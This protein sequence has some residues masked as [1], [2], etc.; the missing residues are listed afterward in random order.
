MNR[1]RI[2]IPPAVI[3]LLAAAAVL[4]VAAASPSPQE[5]KELVV[6][7]AGLTLYPRWNKAFKPLA[8]LGKGQKLLVLRER[9][10]W[11]Q[12]KVDAT[13]QKGWVHCEVKEAAAPS[14]PLN[15]PIAASPTTTGLVAKGWNAAT[16]ARRNGTDTGKVSAIM[17]RQLDAKRFERFIQEGGLK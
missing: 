17:D 16:Y 11:K 15:L 12:V 13:G 2:L 3:V 1:K 8:E 9:G 4:A 14:G 5:S 7:Q 10:A 6:D